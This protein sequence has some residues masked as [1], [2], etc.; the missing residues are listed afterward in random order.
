MSTASGI[1]IGDSSD[2]EEEGYVDL[3][4]PSTPMPTATNEYHGSFMSSS[5][6]SLSRA[7][8]GQLQALSSLARIE[9]DPADDSYYHSET[10]LDDSAAEPPL[11]PEAAESRSS[12]CWDFTLR[13]VFPSKTFPIEDA[14]NPWLEQL[15]SQ[16]PTGM[17][18]IV[19]PNASRPNPYSTPHG[20]VAVMD[21]SKPI[22]PLLF[23]RRFGLGTTAVFIAPPK[24]G[25]FDM[26]A[27]RESKEKVLRAIKKTAE[28]LRLVGEGSSLSLCQTMIVERGVSCPRYAL[29]VTAENEEVSTE[30]TTY[31]EKCYEDGVTSS[32]AFLLDEGLAKVKAMVEKAKR[33]RVGI[34][35]AALTAIEVSAKTESDAYSD[36]PYHGFSYMAR[37]RQTIYV[38]YGVF[39]TEVKSVFRALSPT[40]GF[41]ELLGERNGWSGV[42][43]A[44][45][46]FPTTMHRSR[47]VSE[48]EDAGSPYTNDLLVTGSGSS[49]TPI[50]P[51]GMRFAERTGSERELESQLGRKYAH[52]ER[53]W[54]PIVLLAPSRETLGNKLDVSVL[55]DILFM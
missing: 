41:V 25:P 20:F 27:S 1:I 42:P 38:S 11:E 40:A 35:N 29:V 4:T 16:H 32:N 53:H 45:T 10:T 43:E 3:S 19:L 37:A 15:L 39:C 21:Q 49:F 24:K 9:D 14:I 13:A 55:S 2:G 50:P 54:Y 52:T 44:M 48:P 51:S 5:F 22:H 34:L 36:T 30:F 28:E 31:A 46:G 17:N 12:T 6:A 18:L 7:R 47:D 33:Y 8:E 23:D 26:F